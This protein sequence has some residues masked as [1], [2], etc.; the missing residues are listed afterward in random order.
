MSPFP[1]YSSCVGCAVMECGKKSRTVLGVFK[2][3]FLIQ[4]GGRPEGNVARLG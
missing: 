1:L 4:K 2:S 3:K